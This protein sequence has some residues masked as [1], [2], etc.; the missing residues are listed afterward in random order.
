[1]KMSSLDIDDVHLK[2]DD[3]AKYESDDISGYA[4]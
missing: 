3:N 1:M 2:Y 4:R